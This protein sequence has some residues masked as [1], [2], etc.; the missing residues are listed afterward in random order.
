[1]TTVQCRWNTKAHKRSYQCTGLGRGMQDNGLQSNS[2][3]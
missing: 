2:G 1:M 3:I